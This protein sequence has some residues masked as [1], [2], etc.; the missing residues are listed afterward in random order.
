MK[1][2][3]ELEKAR[4]DVYK[5]ISEQEIRVHENCSICEKCGGLCCK[6][7]PCALI[8]EDLPKKSLESIDTLRE[9]LMSGKYSLD[10]YTTYD[11]DTRYYIRMRSKYAPIADEMCIGS[12]CVSLTKSGCKY[13]SETRPTQGKFLEP[14][15][16]G[17]CTQ[18]LPKEDVGLCWA[19]YNEILA[20]LWKEFH[21]NLKLGIPEREIKKMVFTNA[22]IDSVHGKITEINLYIT[23]ELPWARLEIKFGDDR[24]AFCGLYSDHWESY[25][26]GGVWN[27]SKYDKHT[28]VTTKGVSHESIRYWRQRGYLPD[29]IHGSSWV[30]TP[31][32]LSISDLIAN[33]RPEYKHHSL[34]DNFT[35]S[36]KEMS[37][38]CECTGKP[39]DRE[40]LDAQIIK[41]TEMGYNPNLI[42][43]YRILVHALISVYES[44]A[45]PVPNDVSA[46]RM[47]RTA[48]FELS[49]YAEYLPFD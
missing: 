7:I 42:N 12:G 20:E 26:K 17:L 1:L 38:E 40:T 45:D 44:T 33:A 23:H 3:K 46:I 28:L 9:V 49:N 11:A 35:V 47:I 15:D 43:N 29:K 22:D 37:Y 4:K 13:S 41:M 25:I 14:G 19:P 36:R 10:Y 6:S 2:S 21:K 18:H 27:V 39:I 5:R 32:I 8:P 30:K 48:L 24:T 34:Y 31:I 16:K